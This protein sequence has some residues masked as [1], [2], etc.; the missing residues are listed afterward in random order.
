MTIVKQKLTL[1]KYETILILKSDLS[2]ESIT[3]LINEYQGLLINNGAKNIFIQNR[4]RRHLIYSIKQYHDGIF[5]Q[6]NYE[7]NGLVIQQVSKKVK[8]DENILRY[9]TMRSINVA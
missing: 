9:M 4:G 3:E 8:F 1:N 6:V 2:E 7:G 5:V